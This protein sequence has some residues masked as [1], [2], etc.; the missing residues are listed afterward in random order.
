MYSSAS[1][2]LSLNLKALFRAKQ[3]GWDVVI[4]SDQLVVRAYSSH[5][6]WRP[7]PLRVQAGEAPSSAA[8]STSSQPLTQIP[9]QVQEALSRIVSGDYVTSLFWI[10]EQSLSLILN[11]RWFCRSANGQA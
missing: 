10:A 11:A 1:N 9:P 2:W 7:G 4:L 5:D 3:A 6:A 8:P